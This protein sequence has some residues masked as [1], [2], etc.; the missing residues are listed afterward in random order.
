[1]VSGDGRA[2]MSRRSQFTGVLKDRE[3]NL[4]KEIN[5]V[6]RAVQ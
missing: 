6:T 1:V 2:A 5:Q 3:K 4:P